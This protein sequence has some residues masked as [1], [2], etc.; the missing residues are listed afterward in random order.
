VG[1]DYSCGD[2]GGGTGDCQPTERGRL[3]GGGALPYRDLQR[4]FERDRTIITEHAPGVENFDSQRFAVCVEIDDHARRYLVA[5]GDWVIAQTDHQ[6]VK[7]RVIVDLHQVLSCQYFCIYSPGR[8]KDKDRSNDLVAAIML[9]IL[10]VDDR[11]GADFPREV[12]VIPPAPPLWGD[13]SPQR[14]V[15]TIIR[16]HFEGKTNDRFMLRAFLV[17]ARG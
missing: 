1:I 16:A 7:S 3:A 5:F 17:R 12:G 4:E 9:F 8:A 10:L 15:E 6:Y 2:Y 14:V 13:L 11:F